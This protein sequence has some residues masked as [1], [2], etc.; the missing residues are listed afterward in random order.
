MASYLLFSVRKMF[1]L[2]RKVLEVSEFYKGDFKSLN[3]IFNK[4]PELESFKIQNL[5]ISCTLTRRINKNAK[6]NCARDDVE[7]TS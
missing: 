2:I 4:K 6:K 3:F 1:W 5:L 7:M